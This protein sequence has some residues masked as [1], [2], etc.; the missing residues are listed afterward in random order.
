MAWHLAHGFIPFEV[1]LE[2]GAF[3]LLARHHLRAGRALRPQQL[4]QLLAG[5]GIVAHAF[6]DD[7]ARA[8]Q[9]LFPRLDALFR[10]YKFLCFAG[11][12]RGVLVV[13]QQVRQR[14]QSLLPGDRCTG[15]ALGAIRLVNVFERGQGFGLGDC[16]FQGIGQ[17]VAFLEGLEDGLPA[18]VQ[19]G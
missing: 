2:L 18:L 7:V 8:G 13:E 16:G 4:A 9:R 5:P 10:V 11:Q 3:L 12:I 6:G 1:V 14:F 15:A 17:K 19:F